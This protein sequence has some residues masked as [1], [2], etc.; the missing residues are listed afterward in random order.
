MHL[1]RVCL[2]LPIFLGATFSFGQDPIKVPKVA[3][4]PWTFAENERGTSAGGI[5]TAQTLLRKLFEEKAAFEIISDV[6]S[7][8]AWKDLQFPDMPTTVEE[9]GQVP[10][11][12]NAKQ[13]LDF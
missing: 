3:I 12:P 6:I 13:L 4:Y 7:R 11:L 9:P 2:L 8:A 10:L 5:Q 1:L